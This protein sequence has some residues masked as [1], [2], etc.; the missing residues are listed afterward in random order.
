MGVTRFTRQ[1]TFKVC[2]ARRQQSHL[3]INRSPCNPHLALS[4]TE[5]AACFQVHETTDK[6]HAT[7]QRHLLQFAGLNQNARATNNLRSQAATAQAI[8]AAAS[9][10]ANRFSTRNAGR[11]GSNLAFAASLNNQQVTSVAWS[12]VCTHT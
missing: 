1:Y 8:D 6:Q 2:K 10:G 4:C 7:T 5:T 12:N 3:I 11:V 9:S